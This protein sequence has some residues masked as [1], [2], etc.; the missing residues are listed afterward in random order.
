[1]MESNTMTEGRFALRQAATNIKANSIDLRDYINGLVK[2]NKSS[3]D[4]LETKVDA[5]V[6]SHSYK[7]SEVK[8]LLFH[9]LTPDERKNFSKVIKKFED[10]GYIE[11]RITNGSM[12]QLTFESVMKL[13]HHYGMKSWAQDHHSTVVGMANQKGGTGKTTSATNFAV[14]LA[15]DITKD[16]KVLFIDLDPQGSGGVSTMNQRDFDEDTPIVT[17]VDI[18]L[19]VLEKRHAENIDYL[20]STI[21]SLGEKYADGELP[22]N[23]VSTLLEH[24]VT[25]E[26]II[27][28]VLMN[29]HIDNLKVL[30]AFPKDGRFS[31]MFYNLSLEQ[32]NEL[33]RIFSDVIMP[34]L[35][36][37][38]DFIVF[39]VPPADLPIN[40]LLL[41]VVEVLIAPFTPNYLDYISTR[42]FLVSADTRID[43]L[44][45]GGKN[46]LSFYVLPVNYNRDNRIQD[47]HIIKLA[48]KDFGAAMSKKRIYQNPLF[49]E[50]SSK[51]CTIFDLRPLSDSETGHKVGK[52][53]LDNMQ[54]VIDDF[55]DTITRFKVKMD[56]EV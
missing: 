17:M 41:D 4:G 54:E 42:D 6:Q 32:R 5:L 51:E 31:K 3:S 53:A 44:H 55:V 21:N 40:W 20:G 15:S 8:E 14:G 19:H 29:S 23:T 11:P 25:L 7:T 13:R 26:Q 37:R 38:F 9:Y 12:K 34:I 36:S 16:A 45:S 35:K 28:A 24:G 33:T 27:E 30:P 10:E 39:D 48:N 52:R 49:T 43:H 47:Q 2:V 50:A 1:M 22:I 18:V 46:L 56:D